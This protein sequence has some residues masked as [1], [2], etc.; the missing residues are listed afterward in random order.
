MSDK[1][2]GFLDKTFNSFFPRSQTV[3]KGIFLYRL[4]WTIEIIIACIGATI[5]FLIMR[6]SQGYENLDE[7]LLQNMSLDSFMM[8]MIFI[9]VAIVEITKIPLSAAVYY[10]R[11]TIWTIIF[12]FALV[13]VNISTFETIVTG[14]ER[15]NNNRTNDIRKLII[16]KTTLEQQLSKK[17]LSVS[18]DN[19]AL[20]INQKN[21]ENQEIQKQI[22]TYEDQAQKDRIRIFDQSDNKSEI[23]ALKEA[24][25]VDSNRA[26][27]L[28]DSIDKTSDQISKQK[29]W[30]TSRKVLTEKLK[31]DQKSLEKINIKISE[32]INEVGRLENLSLN[33]NKSEVDYI[34]NQLKSQTKALRFQFE[35]NLK[36]ISQ[37]TKSQ[38]AD[39]QDK[40][41]DR[42]DI[43]KIKK[44]ITTTI[45]E[46]DNKA[47][48]NQVYRVATWFKGWF[49][50]DYEKENRKIEK[51]ILSLERSKFK[52][53]V[54]LFFEQDF[55]ASPELTKQIDKKI[56]DLK[57]QMIENNEKLDIQRNTIGSQSAYSNLPEEALTFA[58]WIWFGVLS[59]IISITGTLL[60]F[61]ALNLQDPRLHDLLNKPNTGLGG[62]TYRLSKLISASRR[63]LLNRV[64]YF[65]KSKP[66][67]IV[68]VEKIVE[69]TV[70][71]IV[72]KPVVEE[73]IVEKVVEVPV[74]VKKVEQIEKKVFVHVPLP[75]DDPDLLKKGPFIYN[76]KN[77]DK[78]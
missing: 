67:K 76:E 72:E 21:L 10:S 1:S 13:A 50:I 42:E 58:F 34:N 17:N 41:Q 71:K 29:G 66:E 60:A 24:N 22:I 57:L 63:Y 75:T 64:K 2:K 65:M 11:R 16:K 6:Q 19:L 52:E 47:P 28:Q 36:L 27:K 40:F 9:I 26:E 43:K 25:R 3:S 14:F 15:I 62:L 69:K 54:F 32:R 23:D 8:G 77:K 38:Q 46:I 70:E 35:E 59:F 45:D 5:G 68:E 56:S 7:S 39:A 33:D 4:A 49:L 44:D 73:K 74:E 61:A 30:F 31:A 53:K 18:S 48:H 78:K 20:Q 51:D 55:V 37:L 12:I